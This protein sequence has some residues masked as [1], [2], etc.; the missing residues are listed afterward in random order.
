[1]Y[2]AVKNKIEN[3]IILVLWSFDANIEIEIKIWLIA[4]L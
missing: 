1:M 4:Q 3:S 2:P